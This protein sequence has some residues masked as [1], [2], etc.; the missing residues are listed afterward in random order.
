M[1]LTFTR[2]EI[3]T[4]AAMALPAN[5]VRKVSNMVATSFSGNGHNGIEIYSSVLL[6]PNKEESVWPGLIFGSTYLVSG[7]LS[8]QTGLKLMPGATLKFAEGKGIKVSGS[9]YLSAQGRDDLKVIFTGASEAK[10]FWN[11]IHF[12][13]NSDFNVLRNAV[14]EYAGKNDQ[15]GVKVASIYV[16]ENIVSKLNIT[17]SRIAHGAGYGIAIATN[18]GTINDDFD[19]VNEFE[20]LSLGNVYQY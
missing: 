3:N 18:L 16:G 6:H 5:E 9:G 13:T 15:T 1:A 17:R 12:Q 14:I 20:D 10:G 2:F 11:G 19:L 8:I 7:N 4:N